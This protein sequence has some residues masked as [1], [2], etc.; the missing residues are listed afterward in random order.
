MEEVTG[1]PF[2]QT[3]GVSDSYRWFAPELC[4]APGIISRASDIFSFTMTVL[5]VIYFSSYSFK[6]I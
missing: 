5:E 1:M 6:R 2:T 4:C 3:K